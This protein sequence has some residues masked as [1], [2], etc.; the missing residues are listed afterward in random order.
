MGGVEIRSSSHARLSTA[1]AA[2]LDGNL[3]QQGQYGVG[4]PHKIP[5]AK[6]PS[7]RIQPADE[8][9]KDLSLTLVLQTTQ[10]LPPIAQKIGNDVVSI[11]FEQPN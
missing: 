5:T 9:G 11:V 2:I 4:V 8:G 1:T 6:Q 10:K 7:I 3:E